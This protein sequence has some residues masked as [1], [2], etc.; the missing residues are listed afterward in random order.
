MSALVGHD[1]EASAEETLEDS[2][3]SPAGDTSRVERDVLRREVGVEKVEGGGEESDVAA[4]VVEASGGRAV[5]AVLGDGI[6]ELLDSVVGD[7]ELVAVEI[8]EDAH[9]LALSL[10]LGHGG[11]RGR[12]GR[13]AGRVAG[14]AEASGRGRGV[15]VDSV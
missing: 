5:E 11:E 14:R 4:D 2:V 8:A 9:G 12:R 10:H 1:P 15:G 6:V 3:E 7:L 13:G